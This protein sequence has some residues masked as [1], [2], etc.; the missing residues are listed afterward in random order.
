MNFT[1]LMLKML[2]SAYNRAD[3]KKV[4]QGEQPKTNIGKILAIGGWGFNIINSHAE[5]VMIWDNIDYAEGRVLDKY[6]KNYGVYRGEAPDDI[7]RVMIKVKV[8]AMLSSGNL[9]TIINAAAILFDVKINRVEACEIFP[10]KIYIFV[11]EEDLD[12]IHKML[13][14]TISCLMRRIKAAGIGMRIFRRTYYHAMEI[15]Y[16]GALTEKYAKKALGAAAKDEKITYRS[17]LNVGTGTIIYVKKSYMPNV[18][19][20]TDNNE[21]ILVTTKSGAAVVAG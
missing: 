1:Y 9:D 21:K 7:Y 6:G 16:T 3:V 5:K 18:Y 12:E 19:I 14:D 15:I 11:E 10:A 8:M 4:E 2:T 20:L 17:N 13:S